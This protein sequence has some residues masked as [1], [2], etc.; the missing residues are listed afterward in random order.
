MTITFRRAGGMPPA[1]DEL[2]EIDEDGRFRMRRVDAVAAVGRFAGTLPG[3]V[4]ERLRAEAD[5]CASPPPPDAGPA[6]SPPPAVVPDSTQERIEVGDQVLA[7]GVYD[8]PPASWAALV[9]DL[10]ALV[11]DLVAHPVAAILL[12]VTTAPP[13]AAL[14]HGG[15]DAVPIDP[16]TLD[17]TVIVWDAAGRTVSE[18]QVT[19]PVP[20]PVASPGW[21]L[22]LPMDVS[23]LAPGHWL[24]VD[25]G[26]GLTGDEGPRRGAL[27]Q[28][29]EA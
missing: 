23:A 7:L 13:T 27:H 6:G 14:R 21:T 18:D 8:D 4:L 19:V 20:Q 26:L 3:D 22:P 9:G 16:P 12:E 29:V 2:L 5:S 25:V 28:L 11:D 10:R 1:T 15:V 17:V 24:Q